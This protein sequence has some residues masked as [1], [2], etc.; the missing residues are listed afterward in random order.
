MVVFISI[1]SP[2]VVI[3]NIYSTSSRVVVDKCLG[4]MS[5][6]ALYCTTVR[7]A[8]YILSTCVRT[9]VCFRVFSTSSSLL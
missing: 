1:Y 4:L 2:V 7:F 5:D 3:L 8:H 9:H 6:V